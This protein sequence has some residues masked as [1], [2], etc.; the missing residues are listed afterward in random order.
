MTKVKRTSLFLIDGYEPDTNTVYQFHGCHWYG[1][2]CLKDRTKRQQNRYNDTCQIDWLV[3][4]NGWDI[5]YSFVSTR[6]CEEPMLEKV[7]LEKEFT[8]CLTL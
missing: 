1:H 7:R 5:N 2:T 8:P 6:E 3:K 4:N